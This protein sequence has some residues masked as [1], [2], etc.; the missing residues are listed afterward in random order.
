MAILD[1]RVVMVIF[2][3]NAN[4]SASAAKTIGALLRPG[5]QGPA[6]GRRRSA[7]S[8]SSSSTTRRDG[9]A[10][11]YDAKAGLFYFGW[12]ATRDRLF[13]WEDLQGNWTT[14]PHGLLRQRVPRPDDVRRPPVRPS[15]RRDQEPRL[16]DEALPDPGRRELYTLAPWE[17]SAFQALG[18]G[19]SLRRAREVRAGAS[20]WETSVDIEIDY[21]TREEPARLPL[22]VVHRRGDPV[23][24]RASASPRSPSR[25]APGS[26][27]PPR[28]TPWAS[29]T[30]S[31]RTR[32]SGSS[33][34]TGRSSRSCSP[35]TAPGKGTTSRGRRRS[36]SRRPHTPCR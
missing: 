12:D 6:R 32:S 11:L 14:G 15:G 30:R 34:R 8:W 17:G 29:P 2:G 10:R 31:R 18:L 16:Q 4:L 25:P 13:G 35:T 7:G 9:Y 28:S 5:R 20:C 21:A 1:Q 33:R 23:H 36:G 24:R 27:T 19:L 3:D 26:P 22:R